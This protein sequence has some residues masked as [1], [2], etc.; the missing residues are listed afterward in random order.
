MQRILKS[1]EFTNTILYFSYSFISGILSFITLP[2]FT[3]YLDAE[4][5]GIWGYVVALNTF[6]T[7]FFILGLNSYFIKEYFILSDEDSRNKLLSNIFWFTCLWT[8]ICTGLV[9]IIGNLIFSLADISV[10]FYPFMF[11]ILISNVST[12]KILLIACLR[13][14]LIHLFKCALSKTFLSV[15]SI[16]ILTFSF[17]FFNNIN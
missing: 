4:D 10:P 12:S 16:V 11:L 6:I 3:T 9:L 13:V 17:L 2:I 5:Y 1:K 8:V 14:A 15:T 7:P